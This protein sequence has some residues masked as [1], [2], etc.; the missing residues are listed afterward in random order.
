MAALD[1]KKTDREL[2]RPGTTPGLIDVPSML[3]VAI[4]GKGNPNIVDGEYARALASLYAIAYTI[5]MS[6]RS[7]RA[8]DGFFEYVVPPLEGLWWMADGSAGV[9]Y[10]RKDDFHW[11]SM[12]R[13][14][15]FVTEEIFRWAQEEAARK[16]GIDTGRAER[17]VWREGLCVQCL[18]TGSYDSEPETIARMDRFVEENGFRLDFSDTRRHHEIYLGDPRKTA[19]DKLRT[20]IRH[21]IVR[22]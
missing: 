9:D 18:H 16:K 11:I 5:R 21:P 3:F 20:V 8:I 17:V 13:L 14:P 6:A 1:F 12:I 15:D 7:G 4:R 22:T 19:P 10:D 2:Y